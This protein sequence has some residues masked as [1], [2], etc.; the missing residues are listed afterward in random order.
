MRPSGRRVLPW[1]LLAGLTLAV[2]LAGYVIQKDRSRTDRPA[3]RTPVPGPAAGQAETPKPP[4]LQLA[5]TK[6][7]VHDPRAGRVVWDLALD[8]AE[9]AT[10]TGEAWFS[11]VSAVYHNPDGTV[12]RLSS[13]KAHLEPGGEALVFTGEVEL[14]AANGGR[15]SAGTLRWEAGREDFQALD[16][17][18]GLVRFIRGG[19]ALEAREFRG[20]MA[21]KKVWATGGVRFTGG[22][23]A[24]GER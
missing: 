9:S 13:G 10:D 18:G 19:T 4:G 20:D 7:R 11:G 1:L 3:G 12:S 16:P 17:A 24:T 14:T 8:E 2:G 21:L 15:L 23:G 5:G 22:D 6:L